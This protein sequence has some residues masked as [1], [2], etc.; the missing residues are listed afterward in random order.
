[1]PFVGIPLGLR[2]ARRGY[3]QRHETIAPKVAAR[4]RLLREHPPNQ[5]RLAAKRAVKTR[6]QPGAP[7][8]LRRH[9]GGLADVLANQQT[10]ARAPSTGARRARGSPPWR[11][12]RVAHHGY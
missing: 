12:S 5:L 6:P 3:V 11:C 9:T 1:V 8:R 2:R 10:P 4:R 7:H